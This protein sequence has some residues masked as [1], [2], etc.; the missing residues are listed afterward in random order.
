M[1]FNIKMEDLRHKAWLMAGG[2]MSEALATITYTGVISR[3][4]VR[5]ALMIVDHKDL[6]VESADILTAYVQEKVT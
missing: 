2:D 1:E 4:T 3:E 5:I 6:E